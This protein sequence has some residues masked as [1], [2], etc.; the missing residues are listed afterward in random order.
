MM[1]VKFETPDRFAQQL[2]S[3]S[4]GHE[5]VESFHPTRFT[6]LSTSVYGHLLEAI[7]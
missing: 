3:R 1:L 2:R 4:C 5:I 7:Q 6:C